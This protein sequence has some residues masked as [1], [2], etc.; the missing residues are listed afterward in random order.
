VIFST[1]ARRLTGGRRLAFS[2]NPAAALAASTRSGYGTGGPW[3]RGAAL[4]ALAII[5]GGAA[6]QIAVP[7]QLFLQADQITYDSENA[8]VTAQGHVEISGDNRT[9]IADRVTYDER[10][11]KV[12]ASGHI[13]LQDESGNVAFA[14]QVELT[15]DLRDGALQGFAA[16]LGQRGRLAANSAERR[17]GRFTIANGAVYTPC[18][19][20]QEESDSAPTWEIR[21]A[22]IVHDQLEKKIYFED[23]S[24]EFLGLPVLY[25]PLFSQSD[26]TVKYQSGFL[27][28]D[29]GSI[30]VLGPFIKLPYYISLSDDRDL[31]IEPFLTLD[32]GQALQTEYRQRFASGGGLW[33]QGSVAFDP[34]A[35][36]Q[37]GQSTWMSSLFGQGR[38]PL[39]DDW[40]IGFDA[41]LSS[42][43]TYLHRYDYSNTDRLT[44]DAFTDIQDGR[45]RGEIVGY[46]FQ[47]LR[48][49]D[50]QSEIPVALP[51]MDYTYIPED[52][53]WGG[54]LRIDASTL[55]LNRGTGTD[56]WRGSSDADWLFPYTTAD[57]Q[58]ISFEAFTRGDAY[59]IRDALAE[60]PNA[61]ANTETIT[62]ALG[63][64]MLEWR[65]PYVGQISGRFIPDNTNLVIE[66][67]A[68]LIAASN[69]GNPRG[70]PDE[71]SLGFAL[72]ATNLF[73][74]N[75]SPG[76][77]LWTGGTRGTFGIRSTALFP[78]GQIVGTFGEEYHFT[79][80][81]NLPP[82]LGLDTKASDLVG[83][84]SVDF[85]PNFSLTQQLSIDPRDGSIRQN[86]LYVTGKFGLSSIELS[87]VKLPPNGADPSIGPQEEINLNTTVILYRNWGVFGVARRDLAQG[88]MLE[89][90]FGLT[91]DNDCFVAAIGFNRRY[92]TILD[93]PPASSVVFHIGLKTGARGS[94]S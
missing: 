32:A 16:L 66:P 63:Y 55:Y 76:L 49:T 86:E 9:L 31:T 69:G 28:P 52:R 10:A 46:Y 67:I 48:A 89:A 82:G 73:N 30:S 29:M 80:E 51:L 11:D 14:D 78:T 42:N 75:P 83:R 74:P 56:M 6:P 4:A 45:S 61:P 2:T 7:K 87:Y 37:P 53:I 60:A 68:E 36:D 64:G 39:S 19:I 23:A 59:Y 71:D 92:T 12:L 57:G 54:R 84:I 24:F 44:N 15:R 77:D 38:I 35:G 41:Q 88:K 91:Y 94:T 70:M 3:L 33:L 62:R 50:Y 90:G 79:T 58:V 18:T 27:L 13:S 93:L 47:S 65:W 17:E 85:P 21:A 81:N 34:R 25:L 26:P 22:R 8:T 40:R 43:K 20:C 5:T 1:L 72:S